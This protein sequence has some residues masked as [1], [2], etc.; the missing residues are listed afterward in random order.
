MDAQISNLDGAM[1]KIFNPKDPRDPR[2]V[3]E[4]RYTY[5]TLVEK[6]FRI[7]N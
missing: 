1:A 5:H 3:D 4:S 6:K 7:Y 2:K